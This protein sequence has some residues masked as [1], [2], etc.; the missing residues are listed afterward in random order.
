MISLNDL[1]AAGIPL[2]GTDESEAIKAIAALEWLAENTT[3]E[4]NPE[5]SGSIEK[6]PASAKLFV[7]KYGE[8]MSLNPGISS[9][10][11]EGLN[12]SFATVDKSA[13]L[14]QLAQSL[15]GRY[16]RQVRVFPAK[17]RW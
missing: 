10:S 13:M 16:L 11:I 17:R 14:W 5:D 12:L 15:L 7:S 8:V 1:I 9:Q 4:I 2:S 3:L 6:L